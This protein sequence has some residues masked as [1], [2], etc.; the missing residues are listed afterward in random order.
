VTEAGERFLC[1]ALGIDLDARGS[2][3]APCRTCLDWSE[4]RPHLAG[5]LG[6]ALCRRAFD[7]AWV[8]RVRDSRALEITGAGRDGF[9]VTFGLVL[10]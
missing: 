2:R 6:A 10:D 7:L 8:A 3:R 4:R 9:R 1:E 5:G